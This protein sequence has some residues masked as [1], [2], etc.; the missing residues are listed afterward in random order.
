MNQREIDAGV[1]RRKRQA[2]SD[3]GWLALTAIAGIL[4]ILG[5]AWWIT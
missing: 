1:D 3:A 2:I 4:T 5:M